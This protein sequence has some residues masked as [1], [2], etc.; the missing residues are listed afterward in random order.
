VAE[1]AAEVKTIAEPVLEVAPEPEVVV[2]PQVVEPEP[3]VVAEP[4]VVEVAPTPVPE[5]AAE[6]P[7]ASTRRG[8]WS[9]GSPKQTGRP[10]GRPFSFSPSR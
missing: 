2:E 8:W 10:A 3:E 5:P 6:A 7:S 1:P 9:R 4:E